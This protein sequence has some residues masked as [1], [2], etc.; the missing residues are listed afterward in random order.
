MGAAHS[1]RS[2]RVETRSGGD[3]RASSVQGAAGWRGG[4]GG[5]PERRGWRGGMDCG[6]HWQRG[7]R[8]ASATSLPDPRLSASTPVISTSRS[9]TSLRLYSGKFK[10]LKTQEKLHVLMAINR[11]DGNGGAQAAARPTREVDLSLM[12]DD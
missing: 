2:A 10:E 12:T 11:G 7:W 8:G 5:D 6:D 4:A 1:F 9:T 3:S